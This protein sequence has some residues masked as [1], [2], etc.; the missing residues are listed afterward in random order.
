M[1]VHSTLQLKPDLK[2]NKVD[3]VC[4]A[5]VKVAE[6]PEVLNGKTDAENT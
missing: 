2:F 1:L 3:L 5:S 4:I 6:V